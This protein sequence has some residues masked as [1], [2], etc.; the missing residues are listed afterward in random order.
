ML[1][2]PTCSERPAAC[3]NGGPGARRL[4]YPLWTLDPPIFETIDAFVTAQMQSMHI[5]GVSIGIVQGDK[6]V[7]LRGFGVANPAGQVMT[8]QTPLILGSTSKSFTALAIMQL[9]EA[10]RISLDTP[11]RDYLP[12]FEVDEP[13]VP[14]AASLITVRHLLNH[15]SGIPT[16]KSIGASLTGSVDETSEEAVRALGKIATTTPAGT[17]FQY[18]NGN[19]VILGLLVQTV[20]GQSYESYVQEH[21]YTPLR[22]QESFVSETEA[23]RHDMAS[24]YRWWFGFPIPG[25]DV[26]QVQ[27]CRPPAPSRDHLDRGPCPLQ[28]GTHLRHQRLRVMGSDMYVWDMRANLAHDAGVRHGIGRPRQQHRHV[29]VCQGGV[30]GQIVRVAVSIE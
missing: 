3:A 7:H 16:G 12:W 8:A 19:Y 22:M 25:D 21:I 30:D 17:T 20:S 26:Q 6:I 27:R 11:V 24:G 28:Q 14:A 15:T 5:P 23:V 2:P 29:R 9:L 1:A 13:L 10:G 4:H 18:S